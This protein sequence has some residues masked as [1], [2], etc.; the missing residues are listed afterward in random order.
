MTIADVVFSL[1]E[2]TPLLIAYGNSP[3]WW[4]PTSEL[5]KSLTIINPYTVEI[6]YDVA[7]FFALGWTI[8]GFYIVPKHIWKPLIES[9][10]AM[11]AFAPDPNFVA[12]GPMRYLKW[13]P[14]SSIVMVANTPGRTV[15]TDQGVPGP[16]VGQCHAVTSTYGYHNLCPVYVDVHTT[17]PVPYATKI[18]LPN[19]SLNSVTVNFDVTLLNKW[20]NSSGIF[21]NLIADKKVLVD[22]VLQTN[23]NPNPQTLAPGVPDVE[24]YSYT[25]GIGLHSIAAIANITGPEYIDPVHPNPWINQTINVVLY[26]WVTIKEDIAGA[27]FL[28]NIAPDCK[29]D[30]KD[31]AVAS[32]AFGTTPGDA[33]WSAVADVSGDYRV[34]G[35]DIARQAKYFGWR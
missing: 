26:I 16:G 13:T 25:F 23:P 6:L 21:S 35:K 3:P 22:D 29:V 12:S 14:T 9:G 8:G 32:K 11:N 20:L 30:G 31:I 15:T 5:V 17:S 2:S 18:N 27:T 10:A 33:R 4:W 7:S 1:V 19:A 24:S 28:G 34:D